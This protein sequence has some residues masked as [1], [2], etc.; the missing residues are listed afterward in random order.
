MKIAVLLSRFRTFFF[1]FYV[2][3]NIDCVSSN[4]GTGADSLGA[5]EGFTEPIFYKRFDRISL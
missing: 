3:S 1:F 2:K 4:Q 5:S